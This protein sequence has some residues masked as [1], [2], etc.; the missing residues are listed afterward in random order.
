MS[1]FFIDKLES[2]TGSQI[3]IPSGVNLYLG[4][5]NVDSNILIPSPSGQ[6][7]KL[8]GSNGTTHAY[9]D[10]PGAQNVQVFTSSGTYTPTAGTRLA[11]V[12][13][14]GAGGGGSGYGESGASGGYAEGYFTMTGV[15]SVSI[16]VGTGGGGTYYS[17]GSSA[18]N[19]TSFGSYMSATGGNG[20]NSSHQHCGG[21]PGVGTGGQFAYYG[22]GGTGH[23]YN[24]R[25]GTNFFGGCGAAGHP[26]GGNYN[27]NHASHAV[28]GTGGANGWAY[29]YVGS[30]GR[31]GMVVIWEYT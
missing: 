27:N 10:S 3:E 19:S 9:Q 17:G 25:G 29:S 7:G 16:T 31:G 8:V 12:R 2:A 24:G 22:G 28:P 14:V 4:P 18:G 20:A 5:I 1:I 23:G 6:T 11:H 15:S 30:T 21:L 26:Q 13:L